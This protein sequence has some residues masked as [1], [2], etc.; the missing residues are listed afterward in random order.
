MKTI[1]FTEEYRANSENE[2]KDE[3]EVFRQKARTEGYTI[4]KCGYTYKQKKSKGEV[5][6]EAWIIS[7]TKVYNDIWD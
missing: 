6:D 7:V 2:A 1:K 3:I 5:I 4:S